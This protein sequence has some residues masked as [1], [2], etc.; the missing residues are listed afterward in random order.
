MPG[1][2][3]SPSFPRTPNGPIQPIWFYAQPLLPPEEFSGIHS[4]KLLAFRIHLRAVLVLLPRTSSCR[5]C[6]ISDC[7][8]TS[9]MH[10][11]QFSLRNSNGLPIE[12]N[13]RP[14]PL[15][16]LDD[17]LTLAESG[18][19]YLSLEHHCTSSRSRHIGL[20]GNI[21]S[22]SLTFSRSFGG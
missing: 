19:S 4:G 21:L 2:T 9:L 5:S 15:L 17:G 18:D 11:A 20:T 12:Y 14:H 8:V 1:A 7:G 22:S 16:N 6:V 13:C 10:R 3:A